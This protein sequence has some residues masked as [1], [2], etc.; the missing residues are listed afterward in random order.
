VL[1]LNGLI[2][3]AGVN[4]DA[5]RAIRFDNCHHA[6][7]LVCGLCDLLYHIEAFHLCQFFLYLWTECNGHMMRWVNYRYLLGS[8][9]HICDTTQALKH[10]TVLFKQSYMIVA[11]SVYVLY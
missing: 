11:N 1:L 4:A 8:V 7:H 3:I 2:Q 9:L 6:V 10:I 5:K